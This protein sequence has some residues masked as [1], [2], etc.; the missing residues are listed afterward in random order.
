MEEEEEDGEE[1][2]EEIRW[3]KAASTLIGTREMA[4]FYEDRTLPLD[5]KNW[6]LRIV[7]PYWVRHLI[8][9]K[10]CRFNSKLSRL[11][12]LWRNRAMSDIKLVSNDPYMS[13]I[14]Q[15]RTKY[16]LGLITEI[17]RN[18]PNLVCLHAG[19]AHWGRPLQ[20]V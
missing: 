1:E 9:S 11:P 4:K 5:N 15:S 13:V 16:G 19:W 2:E 18:I 3:H 10:S 6:H 20:S 7:C 14:N 8:T 12:L 17:L